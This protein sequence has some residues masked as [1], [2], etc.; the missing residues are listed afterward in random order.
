MEEEET[1]TVVDI[2]TSKWRNDL[3]FCEYLAYYSLL[4]VVSDGKQLVRQ[5]QSCF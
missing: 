4:F 5:Q 1:T 2:H 3:H